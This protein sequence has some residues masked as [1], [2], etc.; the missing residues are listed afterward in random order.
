MYSLTLCIVGKSLTHGQ[1][2]DGFRF[3]LTSEFGNYIKCIDA[4][5]E[6]LEGWSNIINSPNFECHG[7]KAKLT[8]R[9]LHFFHF[10]YRCGIT[11]IGQ[12]CQTAETGKDLAQQFEA[13][14]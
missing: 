13:L 10:Q 6:S 12:D 14:A 8:G 2:I 1:G 11:D 3:V 5:P 7:I 9:R 4:R